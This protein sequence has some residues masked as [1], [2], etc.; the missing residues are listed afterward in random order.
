MQN[1]AGHSP[2]QGSAAKLD[3]RSDLCSPQAIGM[4]ESISRRPSA[5]ALSP[6]LPSAQ[7]PSAVLTAAAAWRGPV[8]ILRSGI[9][10]PANHAVT[11]SWTHPVPAESIAAGSTEITDTA[12]GVGL[13]THSIRSRSAAL[14]GESPNTRPTA[15][16]IR[17]NG[18][19]TRLK[20]SDG[21]PAKSIS[22]FHSD[23]V[24]KARTDASRHLG[25]VVD[26]AP[27]CRFFP[28]AEAERLALSPRLPHHR[29]HPLTCDEAAAGI[30]MATICAAALVY[31]IARWLS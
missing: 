14:V 29:R 19:P 10:S 13:T 2:S 25:S 11:P 22:S 30:I 12:L 7:Y 28:E 1:R 31:A 17:E 18:E 24:S 26:A 27:G 21:R 8:A 6:T 23:A 15:Q 16:V 5:P 9:S 3:A 20:K 4:P